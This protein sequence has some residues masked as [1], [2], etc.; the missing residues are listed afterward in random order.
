MRHCRLETAKG[1][2]WNPSW[3]HIWRTCKR[4]AGNIFLSFPSLGNRSVYPILGEFRSCDVNS[5]CR[6]SNHWQIRQNMRLLVFSGVEHMWDPIQVRSQATQ[7]N[8]ACW[9]WA[10][11]WSLC[12]L[13]MGRGFISYLCNFDCWQ[14]WLTSDESTQKQIEDF[15]NY[16]GR[17]K[18]F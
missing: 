3:K 2:R 17:L 4:P 12:P 10:R 15:V 5:I 9:I 1:D 6:V 13:Y 18:V 14:L 16:R 11:M 7:Y 8:L